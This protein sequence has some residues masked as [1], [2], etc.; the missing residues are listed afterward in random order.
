MAVDDVWNELAKT[1]GMIID[2]SGV[3]KDRS[4]LIELRIQ[5]VEQ[6]AA[7]EHTKATVRLL[8]DRLASILH[9]MTIAIEDVSA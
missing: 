7:V 6:A 3:H 5:L 8:K 1:K 4:A 2:L 9:D